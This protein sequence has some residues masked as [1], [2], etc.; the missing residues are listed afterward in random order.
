MIRRAAFLAV[1]ALGALVAFA[2]RP[3][4]AQQAGKVFRIGVL[5]LGQQTSTRGLGA[6]REGLRDL[7]YI[8]GQT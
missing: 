2:P 4:T 1:I 5:S 3:A 8:E 7:G 6:F